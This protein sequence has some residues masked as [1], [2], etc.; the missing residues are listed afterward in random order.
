MESGVLF[1]AYLEYYKCRFLLDFMVTY[2]TIMKL[3][4]LANEHRLVS[5]LFTIYWTTHHLQ[6]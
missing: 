4:K 3:E 2:P 1:I 6:T 5:S